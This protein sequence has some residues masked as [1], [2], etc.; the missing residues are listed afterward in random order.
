M[1]SDSKLFKDAL[2]DLGDVKPLVQERRVALRKDS[3]PP[4]QILRERRSAATRQTEREMNP[5]SGEYIELVAPWDPIEFKRDGV[6]N[7]VYRNLRL[8][9]YTVDARLDLHRHSVEMARSVVVEFIRDCIEADVRCAL[10][11]HGKGE[12]RKQPALLK[13]CLNHWLPQLDEVLAFHSAQKQ[14]G[15]MGA[16]YI[17]LRKSER[18]RQENLERHQRRRL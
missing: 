14:H 8:G 2:G 16:T 11:T 6:Q 5:L 1:S 4:E 3:K 13:S 17:L 18:K 10:I 7:G 9:K 12:G 15:G